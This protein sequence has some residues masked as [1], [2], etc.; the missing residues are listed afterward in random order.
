MKLSLA[1]YVGIFS[2]D[3]LVGWGV[4]IRIGKFP[5]LISS[6][7]VISVLRTLCSL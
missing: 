6:L 5:I 7:S 1:K 2:Q 4:G 3:C